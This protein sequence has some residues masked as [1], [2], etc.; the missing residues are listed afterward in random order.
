MTPAASASSSERRDGFVGLAIDETAF[1]HR[2]ILASA[3][4]GKTHALTNRYLQLIAAGA[5]PSSILASTFTRAAAAEIRDRVLERLSKAAMD[6]ND[7]REL[8]QAL[9]LKSPDLL[10]ESAARA[11]LARLVDKLHVLQL[12][13]LDSFFA[14]VVRASS[15]ELGLPLGAEVIDEEQ[16]TA[17]RS[18]AIARML[19]E[20]NP[21]EL[22]ELLRQLTRGDAGRS[23]T[24]SI[25]AVVKDLYDLASESDAEAWDC[26]PELP[27]KLKLPDVVAE[28]EA[29]EAAPTGKAKRH[30]TG[31]NEDL[32]RARALDWES[33][34]AK[35]MASKIAR[36]QTKYYTEI[37]PDLIAAYQ[38][39]VHHAKAEVISKL[40][41]Q[42]LATRSMVLL[43]HQ[44]L[45]QLKRVRGVITFGD[46]V[47][48]CQRA[49]ARDQLSTIAFRLDAAVHHLLLDEFQDTSIAQWRALQ[50]IVE[51]VIATAPPDRSFFCVGDV[52]QSI[53][54]WRGASP[55]VLEELPSM[56]PAVD[57]QTLAK[58]YRSS[59]VVIDVVNKVFEG[60]ADNAA[61]RDHVE[62]AQAWL[63]GFT[64]HESARPDRQG[65]VELRVVSRVDSNGERGDKRQKAH[66]LRKAAELAAEISAAH[67][68]H[69]IGILVRSNASVA[70]LL[71][72]LGPS[73]LNVRASGRGG[74]PVTDVPATNALLDLLR[75]VDH[76]DDST[77]A[78]NVAMSPLGEAVGLRD[79]HARAARDRVAAHVRRELLRDGYAMTLAKLAQRIAAS[80]DAR[81][82]GRVNQLVELAGQFDVQPS[83]RADDFI[84]MAEQKKIAPTQPARVEV[85]VIH[86]SKGL[87]FDVVILPDLDFR[88]T[89][90]KVPQVL[91]ERDGETG[92]ITRICRYFS[93]DMLD[94]VP[95]LAS[96]HE[97]YTRRTVRE[98]LSLLYVAMTRARHAVH[99]L[100]NEPRA[101]EQTISATAANVV[102]CALAPAERSAGATAYAIGNPNWTLA[103]HAEAVTTGEQLKGARE[104]KSI[105]LAPTKRRAFDRAPSPAELAE[106]TEQ[107]VSAISFDRGARDRGTAIHHLMQQIEWLETFEASDASLAKS[108]KRLMPRRGD[109]W[110]AAQVRDFRTMLAS[111][112]IAAE[113]AQPTSE[114]GVSV[115]RE[116]PFARLTSDG[117][118]HG[119]IDRLVIERTGNTIVRAEVIDFKTD[120]VKE[121]AVEGYAQR[122]RPQ[123]LAYRAAASEMLGID[124]KSIVM[125]IIFL[126]AGR[127][128]TLA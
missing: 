94:F 73:R 76:P 119:A 38:P 19:N 115:R 13:T 110:I 70:R 85:M 82:I 40:R 45:E 49:I 106:K 51:E 60:L 88:L 99:M 79:W 9:Q 26:V 37:D 25:D 11:I 123:L 96:L 34:L 52:K 6:A 90:G 93:R 118:Q 57:V 55:E 59:P 69:S 87:D 71:M 86:Q 116:I 66:R 48:W 121:E 8:A 127:V 64:H 21:N 77:A 61:V 17:L 100:I 109:D 114:G 27:G 31:K 63:E 92:P 124:A 83:L 102:R 2:S 111:Q 125:K 10:T 80:C 28:M 44:Q 18:E 117:V 33:F 12:R 108:I 54:G 72:E 43:Y 36:G 56:F 126:H 3:G 4:S 112:K 107:G 81:E 7:R 16:E 46:L 101:N 67:P 39:L 97:R 98:N 50:P 62:T 113:L 75:M 68:N 58:S 105:R 30:A 91:Y 20:H 65:Y 120:I 14:S 22:V 122:Y 89:G 29:L 1:E 47:L 78:F 24:E 84:A 103:E 32:A 104:A 95:E 42:T 5:S 74:G 128:V 35:G 41:R 53:Y 15:I 23:V